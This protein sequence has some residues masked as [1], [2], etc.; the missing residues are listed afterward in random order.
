MLVQY[1]SLWKGACRNSDVEPTV[2]EALCAMW[3][4]MTTFEKGLSGTLALSLLGVCLASVASMHNDA[5]AS[6]SYALLAF[7]LL[8]AVAAYVTLN[9]GLLLRGSEAA[10][11]WR[12]L[13]VRALLD[14]LRAEGITASD[15]V[16]TIQNEALRLIDRKL[17]RKE[18]FTE[19][20]FQLFAMGLLLSMFTFVFELLDHGLQLDIA[21]ALCIIVAAV[22]AAAIVLSGPLWVLCDN[23]DSM[24][25]EQ[26][27]DFYNDLGSALIKMEGAESRMRKKTPRRW[28]TLR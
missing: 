26:L 4:A 25:L 2:F 24:P 9:K 12:E 10:S 28:R 27:Q 3:D 13:R 7:E 11:T 17:H 5:F 16:R 18:S 22:A 15:Q 1:Y 20:A 6:W 8:I 23:A 19:R 21:A 14:A